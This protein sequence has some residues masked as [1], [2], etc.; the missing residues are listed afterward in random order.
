VKTLT[1]RQP[2]ASLI[3]AGFKDVEN[4]PRPIRYRGKLAIHA[5]L[6]VDCEA[7]EAFGHL[8]KGSLPLGAVIGSVDVVDCVS[9]SDSP[10]ALSDRYHWIL[11]NPRRLKRPV[12]ATGKLGLWDFQR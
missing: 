7:M 3:V 8:I 5:G 10:W 1:V 2:W 9:D 6:K 11:A 4:R 12:R